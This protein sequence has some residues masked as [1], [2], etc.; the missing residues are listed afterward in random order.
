MARRKHP[1]IPLVIWLVLALVFTL[2]ALLIAIG[3]PPSDEQLDRAH[4]DGMAM[5]YQMCPQIAQPAVR[6]PSH[7]PQKSRGLL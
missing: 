1:L 2:F 3:T 7:Q 6:M 5:G 4:A